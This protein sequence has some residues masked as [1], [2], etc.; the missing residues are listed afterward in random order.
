MQI[1]AV[2]VSQQ[3]RGNGLGSA[4]MHWAVDEAGRRGVALVQLTSDNSRIDAHRFYERL[5]FVQSHAGFKT[6]LH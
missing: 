5:G 3:L 2:R 6:R 1:E 4:M